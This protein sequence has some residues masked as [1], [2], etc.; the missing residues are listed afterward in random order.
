VPSLAAS[1]ILNAGTSNSDSMVTDSFVPGVGDVIV[2]KGVSEDV[3]HTLD[4]V[5][6]SNGHT[7]TR[8]AVDTTSG[9]CWTGIWTTTVTTSSSMTVTM[10]VGLP[11]WHSFVVEQ[12]T[13]ASLAATPAT[14]VTRGSG[15]PQTSLTTTAASSAVSWLN[16]DWAAISPAGRTYDATSNTAIEENV[17]DKSTTLYVGY[18]AY[19]VG[20]TAAPQTF[21]LTAPAGQTWTLIGVEV[22]DVPGGGP[23]SDADQFGRFPWQ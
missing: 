16:G 11:S 23:P 17:H 15:A 14:V 20:A 9:H 19:Q 7:Y 3:T 1:F 8:V 2:V 21:G 6:D 4:G 5:T 12:W 13:S 10:A 22:L 18:Y